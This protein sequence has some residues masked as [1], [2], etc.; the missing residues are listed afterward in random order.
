MYKQIEDVLKQIGHQLDADVFPAV[1]NGGF[2]V[3]SEQVVPSSTLGMESDYV[4]GARGREETRRSAGRQGPQGARAGGSRPSD[5]APSILGAN[6]PTRYED[7]LSGLQKVYPGAQLW[8]QEQGVWLIVPSALLRGLGQ[9]ALFLVGVSFIRQA[10]RSWAFWGD[11]LGAP[12][13]IGPRHT[14]FPD[15]SIC[16]FEPS[17]GTWV[18]GSSLVQL[19]DLYTVWALRHLHMQVFGRW[20]GSQVVH[21]PYERLLEIRKDERCGCGAAN[22]NYAD[23]CRDGDLARDRIADAVNFVFWSRGL[24]RPPEAVLTF[25]RDRKEPPPIS[26]ILW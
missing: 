21:H 10:A 19:L 26:L 22:K 20:P 4:D 11:H 12:L 25:M 17:D 13:W 16:A 6:A 8:R 15:G 23:C 2:V 9:H 3:P 7:E 5:Q 1:K 14:N 24:R 18:Y